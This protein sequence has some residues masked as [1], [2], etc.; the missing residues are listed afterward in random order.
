MLLFLLACAGPSEKPDS[1]PTVVAQDR[2]QDG[3]GE[4]EGDCNDQDAAIHPSASELCDGIDNDCD[5]EVD[6]DGQNT[7]YADGDQDGY[8]DPDA[9]TVG[10]NAPSGYVSNSADCRDTNDTIYPGATEICDGEDQNCDGVIDDGVTTRLYADLD[11]D[12]FGDAEAPLD[13]CGLPDGTSRNDDDCDDSV[14][15]IYPGADE[16]CNGIDDN[17]DGDA[18]EG[19][20]DAPAWYY[21][22]DG[23]TYGN[24]RSVV[25]ACEPPGGYVAV[26]S[27]LDCDCN[28]GDA[29]V[30]PGEAEI[31]D[32]RTDEN[33]DGQTDETGATG[34]TV[35]YADSDRDGYGDPT[36]SVSACSAPANYVANADD[37]DDGSRSISPSATEVCN[38]LDDDCDGSIDSGAA[39]PSTWYR[40]ADSDGVGDAASTTTGCNAP[41][42]YV[43]TSGD[44][45]DADPAVSSGAAETCNGMDDDCD[46]TVDDAAVD[47]STW[48][49]DADGDGYG[50]PTA[51]TLSCT[52]PSGSTSNSSDCD[53]SDSGISPAATE[54]CDSA[55]NDCDRSVDE[56]GVCG[57]TVGGYG[58]HRIDK[59]GDYYYALYN[60]RGFGIMGSN[61]WYGS[62]DAAS[63]PEGVTWNED[64]TVFYYN[65][66]GGHVYS[67]T[68]PFGASSTLEGTFALGQIGGGV[69]QG[70]YYYVG[71]YGSGNIYR[72]DL[73]TGLTSLYSSL[74]TACLPY[75]GNSA[76]AID[77]DGTIYAA[78]SCGVVA[79]TANGSATAINSMNNLVSAVAM[80][81]NNELYTLDYSGNISHIDKST[82]A[83]LSVITISV[84]PATTW[85]LAVDTNGDFVVNYWGEQRVFSHTNGSVVRSWSA[86]TYYPGT[87]GY[88]WYVTF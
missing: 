81:A 42:G 32:G 73:N 60:D 34:G 55:D 68:E 14:A 61:V 71:A 80:D 58:G 31:C 18:D 64:Q 15:E 56:G 45:N 12:G 36:G 67:Q 78:G 69:V 48:Y 37:C 24:C 52:A 23:D 75:F 29:G 49:D 19:A 63:A 22:G 33:C 38:G 62:N 20:V 7:F 87:S 43:A 84:P 44:C 85:T 50:D 74:G 10:C 77:T 57:T 59:N 2:D 26:D 16:L 17:C 27:A 4:E 79:Y 41:V 21:D 46:G 28:D 35:W 86:N 3:Y 76:M 88:Y 53:D 30:N 51:S 8:G 47:A 82:G 40:D 25:Y 11:G 1:T 72:L 39:N 13:V 54:V 66:L 5:E 9:A 6:E 70:D 65:D 83:V